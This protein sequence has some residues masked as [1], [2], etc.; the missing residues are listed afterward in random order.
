MKIEDL[1][2][3]VQKALELLDLVRIY[4]DNVGFMLKEDNHFQDEQD[5]LETIRYTVANCESE[6]SK[7]KQ[8]LPDT[9]N[10]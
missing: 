3:E 4:A 2:P 9:F 5:I 8:L 1:S 7:I 6:L 10:Q